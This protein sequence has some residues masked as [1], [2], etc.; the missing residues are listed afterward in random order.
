MD[1][2]L[3]RCCSCDRFLIPLRKTEEA[4]APVRRP[5]P[6]ANSKNAAEFKIEVVVYGVA[7]CKREER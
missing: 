7:I 3:V 4:G 5:S 2:D 6:R 1:L